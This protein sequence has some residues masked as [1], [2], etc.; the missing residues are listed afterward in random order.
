MA[1]LLAALNGIS[2]LIVDFPAIAAIDINPLLCD[3]DGVIAIDARIEIDPARAAETGPNRELPIRP[4]PA[5]WERGIS[6][7]DGTAYRARP[8]KP[9]DI[10]L[11][12]AFLSATSAT[13]LRMRFHT[14]RS[15]F[16]EPVLKRLTQIDY[17]REMAFILLEPESGAMAGVARLAADPSHVSAEFGILMRTDL[18]GRGLGRQLLS[19]L[20]DYA[21]L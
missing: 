14:P 18:K 20:V 7:I 13:D 19:L 8:I 6:A 9:A 12:P 3:A 21:R 16:P 10:A 11:Y 15:H 4:Y 5:D 2:Q 1:A 17:E